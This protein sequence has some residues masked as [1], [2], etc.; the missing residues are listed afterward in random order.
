MQTLPFSL[1]EA[2][3]SYLD[4]TVGLILFGLY[5]I[6]L[7]R[8]DNPY[9]W[10]S[11]S[12][13]CEGMSTSS[14]SEYIFLEIPLVFAKYRFPASTVNKISAGLDLPSSIIFLISTLLF[15][16]KIFT[17]MPVLSVKVS[18]KGFI[19]CSFLAE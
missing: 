10:F 2:K 18:I 1:G 4:I 15:A 8:M 9:Q 3:S 17:F 14:F 5:I 7:E 16:L 19:R 12:L 13:R 11:I 6:T